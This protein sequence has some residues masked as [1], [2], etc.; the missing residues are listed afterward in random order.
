MNGV[1]SHRICVDLRQVNQHTIPNSFPN[2][3]IEEAMEK[4]NGA[5]FRTALDFKNAFHQIMLTDEA[6]PVTAFYFN[7]ALY[8]YVRAPFGH[9]CAM[10]A[11]CCL[12]ALLCSGYEPSSYYADDLMITT[13]VN[14]TKSRSEIYDLHL[15]H[16]DGMLERIIDANLKLVAHKCQWA[17]DASQPMEWLG[18][19]LE[20]N[21]LK[22]QEAKVK[23]IKEFPVPSTAKQVI[24]FVS[25]AS[26]YRRFIKDFA[27]IAK[28][29]HDV[30]KAEPFKWNEEAQKAFEALKEAMCSDTV[31]RMPRQGEVFQ[32]YTDASHIAI[33]AVLCQVDPI[34][35]KSHPCAYGSR[36]FN[37]QELKL[38]TPCKE[39][40]AI[41]YA[42]NLWSFYICGNPV[43]IFSDCRAW[44]FL[45]VQ[46]GVSGKISRLALLV[47][48]YD[49]TVSFV[50]GVKNKAADGLSRAHDTGLIKCDDQVTNKHPA[51]EY[52]GAKGPMIKLT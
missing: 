14:T 29:M 1:V 2:Y 9:V 40:L 10:N 32:L 33:G 51:L 7:N 17:Y 22:P 38:S 13:P 15:R 16:I 50:Q 20:N 28:P 24:S 41:V 46:S 35:K 27:K 47:A 3:W 48:E 49:I 45:K 25:L 4:I 21:L 39:L 30:A 12:M 42:L 6:I 43:H 52:L 36:K 5:Y 44:T 23:S 31:L 37:D 19:T 34:D 18:F 11:F 8:E 26:F